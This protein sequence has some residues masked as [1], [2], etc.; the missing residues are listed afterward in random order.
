MTASKKHP[1][2]KTTTRRVGRPSAVSADA[3]PWEDIERL[4]IFGDVTTRD[5]QPS[6]HYPTVTELAHRFGVNDTSIHKRIDKGGWV[7]RRDQFQRATEAKIAE[8]TA[9][10]RAT[11]YV[12]R[13]TRIGHTVDLLEQAVSKSVRR[14]LE[15][16]PAKDGVEEAPPP[17]ISSLDAKG[18]ASALKQVAETQKLCVGIISNLDP[19]S[20]AGAK[21][22]AG[23]DEEEEE[24]DEEAAAAYLRARMAKNQRPDDGDVGKD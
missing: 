13:F 22:A 6:V 3:I 11:S 19:T 16:I 23:D 1:R 8:K 7:A 15:P 5:G 10:L 14:Y 18:F 20:P 2:T 9:D 17:D 12:D 24:M 21:G 4:F